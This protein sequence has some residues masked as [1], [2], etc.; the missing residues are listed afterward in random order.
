MHI[1]DKTPTRTETS[2]HVIDLINNPMLVRVVFVKD[3]AADALATQTRYLSVN[4]SDAVQLL[5]DKQT[6]T[7]FR[8]DFHG[9]G[10]C[11]NLY[12]LEAN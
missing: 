6:A 2:R 1:P 11:G 9:I 12:L 5:Q 4:K 8:A 10:P 3:T 7:Y